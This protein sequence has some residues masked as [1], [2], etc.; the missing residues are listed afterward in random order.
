MNTA[1][2]ALVPY[3]QLRT[4]V[5]SEDIQNR[6]TEVLGDSTK[7]RAFLASLLTLA[8]SD[9]LK[10]CDP[11][12]MLVSAMKAAALDLPIDPNIGHA[13]IVPYRDGKSGKTL[14]QFQVGYRGFVQLAL[15]TNQ[16]KFINV[17]PICEGQEIKED[18]L[19]GE[20]R[21]NGSRQGDKIIGFAAY[22]RLHNGFE[23]FLYMTSDAIHTHAKR[24][25]KSYGK[26]S[27]P[28]STDFDAMAKKTV[29]K[30]L[31]SKY[32]PLSIDLKSALAT[33]ETEDDIIEGD[34][35]P[36]ADF[37]ANDK[38]IEGE[39]QEL[40]TPI[41]DEPDF[42]TFLI[43]ERLAVDVE[44]AETMLTMCKVPELDQDKLRDWAKTFNAWIDATGATMLQAAKYANKGEV[45]K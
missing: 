25:S 1:T 27:S 6:F 9:H 12:S 38:I 21:V 22:F 45:P 14:A 30:L 41:S 35:V 20:I 28:W 15:R 17:A 42:V 19:T 11:N 39:S 36:V 23:K 8:S 5:R 32:G 18:Q 44:R 24:F 33:D 37:F 16:Y 26:D 29:L 13:W 10:N 43:D 31:I 40:E 2:K 3:E 4:L 34:S 7:S